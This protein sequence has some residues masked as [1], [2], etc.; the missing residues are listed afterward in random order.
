A[1]LKLYFFDTKKA[2]SFLKFRVYKRYSQRYQCKNLP[3]SNC[4]YENSCATTL[5]SW[6]I[7]SASIPCHFS[8]LF[9]LSEPHHF[10]I[11]LA[12]YKYALSIPMLIPSG[13]QAFHNTA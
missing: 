8:M 2:C 10:G 9:F 7:F 11:I 1:F 4:K 6:T 3:A 5:V 12:L 13:L